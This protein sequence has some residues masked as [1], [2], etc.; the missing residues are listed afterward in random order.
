MTEL[1]F[2]QHSAS[3]RG[4]IPVTFPDG[5]WLQEDPGGV[6][7]DLP[8]HLQQCLRLHQV[9]T[10]TTNRAVSQLQTKPSP[11]LKITFNVDSLFNVLFLTTVAWSPTV[12]YCHLLW[13]DNDH[14]DYLPK[15][16]LVHSAIGCLVNFMFGFL[17]ESVTFSTRI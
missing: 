2:R 3:F 1:M 11:G 15:S 7:E 12:Y 10:Y 5:L 9:I 13:H 8:V 14:R 17:P 16:H 6:S 4:S